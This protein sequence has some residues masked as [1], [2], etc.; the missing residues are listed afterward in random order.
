MRADRFREATRETVGRVSAVGALML[1]ALRA[2]ALA[3]I[4]TL[5]LPGGYAYA[6]AP[7][8]VYVIFDASNSM[9]GEL[10]DKARKI[11]VAKAVLKEFVGGDFAGRELALRIYGQNRPGDCTDTSVVVPFGKPEA[12]LD[13]IRNAVAGTTPRG[14]TPIDRSLR[15]ALSDFGNRRGDILLISDGIETC[16]A[17]P[18]DLMR[19]WR[20]AGVAIRV[21]VVGL[22]LDEVA[23]SAMQCV[24]ETSGAAYYD[25]QSASQL[26][27]SLSAAREA[28]LG[29]V[30]VVGK[31]RPRQPAQGHELKIVAAD[32]Q[33]RSLPVEGT[34]SLD[35]GEPI[36]V[37]SHRRNEVK[38]GRYVVEVGVRLANGSLYRPV[39]S[40]VSVTEPG[41]TRLEV[42]VARPPSI[43]TRFVM[44]GKEVDGALVTAFRN[45][46]E[47]FKFRWFDEPF[48][49]PGDYELHARVDKDNDLSASASVRD[50]QH[51]QVTFDLTPT[52]RIAVSFRLSTGAEE[53]RNSELWR[54]GV[55]LY[56]IHAVNGGTVRPGAYEVRSS[57]KFTP[58]E[59][60]GIVVSGEQSQSFQVPVTVGLLNVSYD[61]AATYKRLP[62]RAFVESTSNTAVGGMVTPGK[63]VALLPGSYRVRAWS[64]AGTFEPVPVTVAAGRTSVVVLKPEPGQSQGGKP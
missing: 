8:A 33:G 56:S 5:G 64:Q 61:P 25:A 2:A 60:H 23:R 21:H 34:A 26:A 4:C 59:G 54:D 57:S 40:E 46:T 51:T 7:G 12:V 30:P 28:A 63:D 31:P 58:M 44:A 39:R 32:E 43:S 27:A 11:D 50:G 1:R 14:K 16:D 38:Q 22:G 29:D 35:G 3:T 15:A 41:E 24:A 55:K 49:E 42:R 10:P 52:V 47:A 20:E 36:A 45:G 62:D 9:W 13:R 18:C 17:D 53:R 37:A 48:A 19:E 6:E